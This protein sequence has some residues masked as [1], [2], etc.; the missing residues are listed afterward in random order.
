MKT[1]KGLFFGGLGL[2]LSVVLVVAVVSFWEPN[3]PRAPGFAEYVEL[4]KH[5]ISTHD[6]REAKV[7]IEKKDGDI[8]TEKV[9]PSKLA[10]KKPV[11]PPRDPKEWLALWIVGVAAAAYCV[12]FLVVTCP[13]FM[14]QS[15]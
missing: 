8:I 3:S 13:R 2:V 1:H 5:S 9:D 15:L 11:K 14:V 7:S 6:I 10:P 4:G 12:Y